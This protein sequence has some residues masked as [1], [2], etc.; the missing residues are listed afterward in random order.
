[1]SGQKTVLWDFDGTLAYRDGL[2]SGCLAQVLEERAPDRGITRDDVRPL[3]KAGFPWHRPDVVHPELSEPD[4]W[5][6]EIEKL[7]ARAIVQLK[8]TPE[9]AAT[10]AREVHERYIDCTGFR[11]FDD[12]IPVLTS[13]REAG[14]RH[15]ILSNHV[16]EL[17]DIVGGLQLDPLIDEVFSSAVTGYEKPHPRS[18]EIAREAAGSPK[19]I[20]MV[21]DNPA[22]DV[23]GAEAVGI[24]G[25]LVRTKNASVERNAAD[26][27]GAARVI[28]P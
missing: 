28:D 26:L 10:Y 14:W 25:I 1:M 8:F 2:W 11:L 20:W 15:I 3:L 5:W 18:Y 27:E 16:P 23:R 4:A 9:E 13:L 17:A 21:G 24:P 6:A 22:P 12:T 19:E 7:L